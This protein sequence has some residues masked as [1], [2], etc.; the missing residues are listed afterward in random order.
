MK[1]IGTGFAMQFSLR[2]DRV[3]H[4][5]QN[6]FRSRLVT[7]DDDLQGLV[8]YV[9]LNPVEAGIVRDLDELEHWPW[10][11]HAALMGHRSAF[12]FE[13]AHAILCLFDREETAARAALLRWMIE[14]FDAS[15]HS[16]ACRALADRDDG[17]DDAGG[18]DG[19]RELGDLIDRACRFYGARRDDLA[20]GARTGR[21]SSARALICHVAVVLF[22]MEHSNVAEHVGVSAAAV[23]QAATRGADL[24]LRDLDRMGLPARRVT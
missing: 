13:D 7:G 11:G 20:R 24:A 8:R 14:G 10:S 15:V 21:V 4:L 22:R 5:F 16:P 17:S 12:D 1:R 6:R 23:C 19:D 2:H 18:A 9:H 3:G